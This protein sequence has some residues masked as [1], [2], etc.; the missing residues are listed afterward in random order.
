MGIDGEGTV[1]LFLTKKRG[2]PKGGGDRG[3]P[4]IRRGRLTKFQGEDDGSTL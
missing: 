2:G 3:P 4:H 1:D